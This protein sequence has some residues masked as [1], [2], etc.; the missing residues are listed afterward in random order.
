MECPFYNKLKESSLLEITDESTVGDLTSTI[1][2]FFDLPVGSVV[3]LYSNN[4]KPRIDAKIATVK[5]EWGVVP[6]K[7]IRV[8]AEHLRGQMDVRNPLFQ[9]VHVGYVKRKI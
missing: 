4:T 5:K 9:M 1:E 7:V 3:I 6:L 2:G 8:P